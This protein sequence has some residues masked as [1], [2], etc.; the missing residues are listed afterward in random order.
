MSDKRYYVL[1]G[2]VFSVL[3]EVAHTFLVSTAFL[4]LALGFFVATIFADA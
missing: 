1:V 4:A 2:M 3:C